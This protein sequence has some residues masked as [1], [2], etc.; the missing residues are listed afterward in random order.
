MVREAG[1][2]LWAMTVAQ[3]GSDEVGGEL[4][5]LNAQ[6]RNITAPLRTDPDDTETGGW[7]R[8]LPPR[9]LAL[10]GYSRIRA[11]GDPGAVQ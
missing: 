6:T 2:P 3:K 9:G 11:S 7:T 10:R 1:I 8:I 4:Q 5:V